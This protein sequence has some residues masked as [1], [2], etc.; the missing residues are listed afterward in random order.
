MLPSLYIIKSVASDHYTKLPTLLGMR[1]VD[2]TDTD[3]RS[4]INIFIIL[5]ECISRCD[6]ATNYNGLTLARHIYIIPS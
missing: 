3:T 4:T 6:Y 1:F 2:V 5:K